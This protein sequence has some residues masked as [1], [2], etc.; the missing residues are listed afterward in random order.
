MLVE[1]F[2]LSI[3]AGLILRGKFKNLLHIEIKGAGFIFA[4]LIIRKAPLILNLKQL[5]SFSYLIDSIA[6]FMFILSYILILIGITYNL[7]NRSMYLLFSGT[8]MNLLVVFANLGYM[9]VSQKLL[10]SNGF[11]LNLFPDNKL[12]MNHVIET[13]STNLKILGDIILIPRPYP[14]P[15]LLSIG[16]VFMCIGLFIFIVSAMKTEHQIEVE[17]EDRIFL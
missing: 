8:V 11:D 12:D 17:F 1:A 14:F 2:V 15:Q 5:E 7:K 3:L 16:D 6:P 10:I 13:A 9:P 4:A